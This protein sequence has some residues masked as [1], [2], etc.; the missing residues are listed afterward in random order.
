VLGSAQTVP[1]SLLPC[2]AVTS[3]ARAAGLLHTPA[4]WMFHKQHHTY[5]NPSPWGAFAVAPVEAFATFWPVVLLCFPQAPIFAQAYACWT[6]GEW[7]WSSSTLR[8]VCKLGAIAISRALRFTAGFVVL[9]L[10]LHC[11]FDVPVVETAASAVGLNTSR[12]HNV[13][14]LS[15]HASAVKH[16][17]EHAHREALRPAAHTRRCACRSITRKL[18]GISAS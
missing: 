7:W 13:S 4:F 6:A 5:H 3:A 18:P 14:M 8:L 2:A 11:G 10:Y 16:F 17:A 12:F 15:M 1:T 9:N